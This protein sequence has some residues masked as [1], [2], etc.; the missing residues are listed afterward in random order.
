MSPEALFWRL[1]LLQL[2]GECV[3][4]YFALCQDFHLNKIQNRCK[5]RSNQCHRLLVNIDYLV[6]SMK[7]IGLELVT[8]K[9]DRKYSSIFTKEC[10]ES[11]G[12][13]SFEKV[14]KNLP[15]INKKDNEY[16]KYKESFK[17][18]KDKHLQLLSG[19]NVYMMFQKQ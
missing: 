11:D 7:S 14:I 2:R 4:G 9:P 1:S 15:I 10:L 5:S 12:I 3:Q 13:G 16:K 8:P 19:L 17:I 6:D 18:L